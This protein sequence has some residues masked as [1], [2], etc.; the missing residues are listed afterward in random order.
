MITVDGC[1]RVH[2]K[3][4]GETRDLR[5]RWALE[6]AGLA[7]RV[8]GVDHT[9]GEHT[10]EAYGEKSCFSQIPAIED[11]GFIL[12]ES[13]A[14]LLYLAEKSGRLIPQDVEGRS[15]VRQWC[16]PARAGASGVDARSDFV[17]AIAG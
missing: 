6:E 14:I 2:D 4:I 16:L 15:R 13:A 1:G 3:V 17:R 11:A 8:H 7:Y 10:G 9:G 12:S 5:A